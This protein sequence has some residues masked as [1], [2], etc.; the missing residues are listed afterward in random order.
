MEI[1]NRIGEEK[2]VLVV[3]DDEICRCVT[4]EILIGFGL[5]VDVAPDARHAMA[6][7]KENSYDLVLLDMHMPDVDGKQLAGMLL[8]SDTV[9]KNALFILTGAE[10]D[11]KVET[12][13]DGRELRVIR[14][15]LDNA[16][17]ETYFSNQVSRK[18]SAG[19]DGHEGA[20]ID[21]FD[22]PSAI[23]NFLGYEGAFFNI[24]REFPDYGT[25]FVSEYSAHL[26][27]KNFKEC[28]RLAHS[29]KGSSLMI[30]A[31]EINVLAKELESICFATPDVQQIETV[32]GKIEKKILEAAENVRMY[33]RQQE[34]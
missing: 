28:E 18:P 25:N 24:L 11:A 10:G 26:R 27:S 21:G 12:T 32:F 15:P 6:L 9:D 2:T 7:T 31:T 13:P 5:R 14:K 20:Q 4:A 17:V 19:N 8:E 34:Q 1:K 30:G 23:K 29:I 3:D 16:W 33:F 22:I